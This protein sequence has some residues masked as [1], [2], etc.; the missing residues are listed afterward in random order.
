VPEPHE[1][2]IGYALRCAAML[3]SPPKVDGEDEETPC[4]IVALAVGALADQVRQ[5]WRRRH[6][7]T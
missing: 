4:D 5:A 2:V 1:D 6:A 7:Q 3:I